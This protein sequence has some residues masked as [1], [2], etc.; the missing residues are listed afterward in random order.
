MEEKNTSPADFQEPKRESLLTREQF[1]ALSAILEATGT[2][3]AACFTD[4]AA[5]ELEY[6][7][8]RDFLENIDLYFSGLSI[9]KTNNR[10]QQQPEASKI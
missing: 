6:N 1:L 10:E 3:E 5:K 7:T 2:E 9:T 4:T 8:R